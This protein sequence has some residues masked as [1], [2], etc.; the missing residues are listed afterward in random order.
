MGLDIQI[1]N[2]RIVSSSLRPPLLSLSPCRSPS[3]TL[4]RHVLRREATVAPQVAERRLPVLVGEGQRK[5]ADRPSRKRPCKSGQTPNPLRTRTFRKVCR[6]RQLHLCS[7]AASAQ[8]RSSGTCPAAP[9]ASFARWGKAVQL[10][11]PPAAPGNRSLKRCGS[12][13]LPSLAT[14][15]SI[16]RRCAAVLAAAGR[17]ALEAVGVVHEHNFGNGNK[18]YTS[19]RI[20]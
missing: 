7:C 19:I 20:W 11:A 13:N 2:T 8:M 6:R 17:A 5:P 4:H 12:I 14:I 10:T 15:T 16:A 1:R 3:E 9:G 18:G